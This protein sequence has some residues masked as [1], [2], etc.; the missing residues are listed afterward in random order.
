M[1]LV[2]LTAPYKLKWA[3]DAQSESRRVWPWGYL[4][5]PLTAQGPLPTLGSIGLQRGKVGIATSSALPPGLS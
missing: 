1:G 2:H 5:E 3:V 4:P